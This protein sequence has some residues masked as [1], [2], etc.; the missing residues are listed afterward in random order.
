VPDNIT[1]AGTGN[2]T[3]ASVSKTGSSL[4]DLATRSA[5]ALDSGTLADS[6]LEAQIDRVAFTASDSVSVGNF[7]AVGNSPATAG[8][9]RLSNNQDVFARNGANTDNLPI[10]STTAGNS[11]QLGGLGV[12]SVVAK[13]DEGLRILLNSSAASQ[14]AVSFTADN[15]AH[16]AGYVASNLPNVG[17]EVLLHRAR[18]TTASAT[19]V[20]AGD[21]IGLMSFWGHDGNVY[22]ESTQIDA[23][24]EENYTSAASSRKAA[25]RFRALDGD[26]NFVE[27]WRVTSDGYFVSAGV[28][29]SQ[30]S[31]TAANGSFVYCPDCQETAVC[32][33]GGNGAFAKR[34]NGSWKCQ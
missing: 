25:I 15:E 22:R 9:L 33:A 3:W 16:F 7:V 24:A 30:L 13:S 32:E 28:P 20:Q 23:V 17:A 8:A 31:A 1:V 34:L 2:V 21:R 5:D 14:D 12:T 4:G 19:A 10:F 11:V 26:G 18:G 6:R 27:R 29:F